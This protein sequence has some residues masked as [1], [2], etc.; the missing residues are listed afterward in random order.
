MGSNE[1]VWCGGA[2][3]GVTLQI[4]AWRGATRY[5]TLLGRSSAAPSAFLMHRVN[6]LL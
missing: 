2:M 4:V 3:R 1:R 6:A 5:G